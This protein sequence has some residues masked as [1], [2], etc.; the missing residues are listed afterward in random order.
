M[1]RTGVYILPDCRMR[2]SFCVHIAVTHCQLSVLHIHLNR[3]AIQNVTGKERP[4]DAGLQFV[5]QVAVSAAVRQTLDHTQPV[6]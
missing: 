5:L 4:A 6:R 2:V 1:D 3:G